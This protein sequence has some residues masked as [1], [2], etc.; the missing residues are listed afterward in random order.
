M[1][2]K[3]L[4]TGGIGGLKRVIGLVALGAAIVIV[5]CKKT[6]VVAEKPTWRFTCPDSTVSIRLVG[7][8]DSV[9]DTSGVPLSGPIVDIPEYHDCQRFI[10]ASGAYGSV[11][12]IFAAYRLDTVGTPPEGAQVPVGTIYTPDGT[13]RPLGIEPGYNCLI[14]GRRGRSWSAVMVP[15]GQ[16][17]SVADCA[18]VSPATGHPLEVKIQPVGGGSDFAPSDYPPVARWDWDPADSMQYIGIRCGPAWCEVG[19]SGFKQSPP[20]GGPAVSFEAP[21]DVSLPSQGVRR[22]QQIKGWYDTQHLASGSGSDQHPSGIEGTLIPSPILDRVNW[23]HQ[24]DALDFYRNRWVHVATAVLSDDYGKRNLRRGQTRIF[25][26]YGSAVS[27]G[28]TMPTSAVPE[29]PSSTPLNACPVDPTD[30][31]MRWWAK[32]VA[33]TGEPTYT[34]V[35]RMDHLAQLVAWNAATSSG[36]NAT[37]FRIPGAARWKFL[38]DDESTWVSCPSGCCS[39]N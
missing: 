5:A 38:L 29:T 11:Y 21:A 27:G 8:N 16:G 22:V 15:R 39:K 17:S 18:N 14:L 28:C 6:V 37:T 25:L 26:C 3:Q 24:R 13:Y 35:K 7:G 10:D 20:Y 19:A 36:P 4:R 12:A 2:R 30:D 1:I 9:Q 31:T 33:E 34:C 32:T 23:L